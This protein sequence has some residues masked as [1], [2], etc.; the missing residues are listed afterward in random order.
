MGVCNGSMLATVLFML[1]VVVIIAPQSV[2]GGRCRLLHEKPGEHAVSQSL[3]T[4][5]SSVGIEIIGSI[6]SGSDD[7]KISNNNHHSVRKLL[8]EHRSTAME[9]TTEANREEVHAPPSTSVDKFEASKS[10]PSAPA[11]GTRQSSFAFLFRSLAK[12]TPVPT[13]GTPSPGHN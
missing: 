1:L 5:D 13:P 8:D 4:G 9:A 2:L 10:V 11:A 6:L 12:G 7:P 3:F